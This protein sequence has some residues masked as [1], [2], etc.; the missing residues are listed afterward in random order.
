M[1][2]FSL[3]L[4]SKPNSTFPNNHASKFSTLL[5]SSLEGQWEVGVSE[6]DYV[7]RVHFPKNAKLDVY[8]DKIQEH[9]LA[10]TKPIQVYLNGMPSLLHVLKYIQAT[11]KDI[12]KLER[13]KQNWSWHV[14]NPHYIVVLSNTLRHAVKLWQDVL[15][16]WDKNPSSYAPVDVTQ[17][18]GASFLIFIPA[19]AKHETHVL[20][21]QNELISCD[22][23]IKRLNK[24]VNVDYDESVLR[25]ENTK[26]SVIVFTPNMPLPWRQSGVHTNYLRYPWN[27]DCH[28]NV[29]EEWTMKVYSLQDMTIGDGNKLESSISIVY[30]AMDD[31]KKFM[32]NLRH[33]TKMDIS[34]RYDNHVIVRMKDLTRHIIINDAMREVLGFKESMF[35][36]PYTYVSQRPL[37]LTGN[38]QHVFVHASSVA[39]SPFNNKEER[40]LFS[41]PFDMAVKVTKCPYPTYLPFDHESRQIDITLFDQCGRQLLLDSKAVTRIKLHF[42]KCVPTRSVSTSRQKEQSV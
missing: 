6:F 26:Q 29:K 42:Q 10:A 7:P 31:V 23:L 22:I 13:T 11:F 28:V 35:L 9:V 16:P 21:A 19:S 20:K 4:D 40:I 41:Q 30:K 36:A 24:H 37:S 17:A 38:V 12:L 34:L 33:I 3:T 25:L 27:G 1:S 39:P 15:T 14:T 8:Q 2:S 18:M 32:F 5:D